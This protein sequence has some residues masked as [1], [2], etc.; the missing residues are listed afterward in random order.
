MAAAGLRAWWPAYGGLAA[1]TAAMP[2]GDHDR[3]PYL[4]TIPIDSNRAGFHHPDLCARH[5]LCAAWRRRCMHR[6]AIPKLCC[7]P[8]T[9]AQA[10]GRAGGRLRSALVAAEV[11][12]AVIL[13][14]G[15]GLALRSLMHMLECGL[16]SIHGIC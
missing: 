5:G 3:F 15:S 10:L 9:A 2:F 14:V 8:G 4:K 1:L 6:A 12:L 16:G 13:L 7:S 11:A